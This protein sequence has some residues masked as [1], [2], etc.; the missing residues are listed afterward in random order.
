MRVEG[1][2][3]YELTTKDLSVT[4]RKG[5]SCDIEAHLAMV[6]ASH[7]I[8]S[9]EVMTSAAVRKKVMEERAS[10]TLTALPDDYFEHISYS[11]DHTSERKERDRML[12]AGRELASIRLEKLTKLAH[13]GKQPKVKPTLKEQSYYMQQEHL[14]SETLN[15]IILHEQTEGGMEDGS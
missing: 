15:D 11:L 10:A 5:E 1:L 3:H 9:V 7:G 12:M 13:Q 2:E 6:L 14:F 4:I 8:V